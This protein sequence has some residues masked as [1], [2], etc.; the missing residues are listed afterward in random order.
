L[1]SSLPEGHKRNAGAFVVL[2]LGLLALL[3]VEQ[4]VVHVPPIGYLDVALLFAVVNVVLALERA[5]AGLLQHGTLRGAM[6]AVLPVA[7]VS[8]ALGTLIVVRSDAEPTVVATVAGSLAFLLVFVFATAGF[9]Y[10][11]QRRR[12]RLAD[13]ARTPPTP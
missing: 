10:L 8:T 9:Q 7:V 12:G 2:Y 1:P 11:A 4:F 13:D 6:V 5:R 3:L